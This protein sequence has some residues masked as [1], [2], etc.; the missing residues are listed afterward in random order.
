MKGFVKISSQDTLKFL[1]FVDNLY[2]QGET[3]WSVKR[4]I[5]RAI[6]VG[7]VFK[8]TLWENMFKYSDFSE[9]VVAEHPFFIEC[10][11]LLLLYMYLR[12][13][14]LDIQKLRLLAENGVRYG[15]PLLVDQDVVNFLN[16]IKERLDRYYESKSVSE[17]A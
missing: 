9:D 4:E 12:Y 17:S 5:G 13:N 8:T 3:L 15:E 1:V 14:R 7:R 6:L 10:R 11:P 2:K 16:N